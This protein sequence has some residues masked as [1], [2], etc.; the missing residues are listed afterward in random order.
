GA[1][2]VD[3]ADDGTAGLAARALAWAPP[4]DA[5]VIPLPGPIGH[6]PT[7]FVGRRSELAGIDGV[8]TRLVSGE[9]RVVLVSGEPG[10]GKT[11]LVGQFARL[12]HAANANVLYGRCDEETLVPYQPFVEAF[13]RYAEV[14][15]AEHLEAELGRHRAELARL[16]PRVEAEAVGLGMAS[17]DVELDRYR[18]FEAVAAVLGTLSRARPTVL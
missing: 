15:P 3:D 8:L 12:A 17:E 4:A 7:V 9:R 18:M 14:R 2:A 13:A 11:T 5:P 10:I 16:V 6:L 1:P